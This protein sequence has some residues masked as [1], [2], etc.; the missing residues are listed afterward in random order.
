MDVFSPLR[1]LLNGSR[2]IGVLVFAVACTISLATAVAEELCLFDDPG[3]SIQCDGC[4]GNTDSCC[5]LLDESCF[6]CDHT[7]SICDWGGLKSGLAE[8]GI[9]FQGDVT[10]FYMGVLAGGESRRDAFAGHGDYVFN[11]DAGK[12]G[13]QEGLFVK[14]R[15]EHRFGTPIAEN[16]GTFLPPA[17]LGDLPVVDSE[18]VY[19]TNVLLTQMFSENFGVFAGKLDTLDG[20]VNA[21]AHGRG[22]TQFSNAALVATPIALRTVPYSTLGA[23]FVWLEEGEPIFTFTVL[24][25]TDTARTSGF[26]EL[27]DQGVS[28]TAELRLPTSF[29]QLPGHQLFGGSW[30]SRNYGALDQDP[31]VIFPSV[32]IARTSGSWSL[33]WN[34]DQYLVVDPKDPTNGWGVFG[35]A[36]IAD[37]ASNPIQH[38]LSF[39]VGGTSPLPNR[40]DDGFGVGWYYSGTSDKISPFLMAFT[41][42]VGDGQGVEL[43]YR[44]QITPCFDITPDFQVLIPGREEIDTAYLLGLRANVSF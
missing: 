12:L 20:D 16:T 17:V 28:L 1:S 6:S 19:L 18:N 36:G 32:P 23:G 27:F 14:V 42:P 2:R 3:L 15:A 39:G 41:G 26:E 38:F 10:G 4:S 21:F 7:T 25:P 35:R 9:S 29:F 8:S 44:A 34:F 24:N 11:I 40:S 33:Y 5:G 37:A 30:S 13:L 31:R 22:K 43:F